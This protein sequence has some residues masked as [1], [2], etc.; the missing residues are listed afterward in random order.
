MS[1]RPNLFVYDENTGV[2]KNIFPSLYFFNARLQSSPLQNLKNMSHYGIAQFT[3]SYY[4]F[5]SHYLLQTVDVASDLRL[6]VFHMVGTKALPYDKVYF[7]CYVANILNDS[8]PKMLRRP[9]V[10]F[11]STLADMGN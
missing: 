7:D 1:C 8:M 3:C 6:P 4:S 5:Y 10:L 9:N 11:M 2:S